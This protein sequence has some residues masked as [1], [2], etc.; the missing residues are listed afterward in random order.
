MAGYY[1]VSSLDAVKCAVYRGGSF[2][3]FDGQDRLLM[4]SIKELGPKLCRVVKIT[5]PEEMA[6]SET[7][8]FWCK[9][10]SGLK[11]WLEEENLPEG[12]SISTCVAHV[13]SETEQGN[14]YVIFDE[15]IEAA[16]KSDGDQRLK[17]KGVWIHPRFFQVYKDGRW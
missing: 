11:K 8:P 6:K 5:D 3:F 9:K 12:A 16:E 7:M 15:N 1:G 4:F 14:D 2:Y 17:L 10:E 13:E